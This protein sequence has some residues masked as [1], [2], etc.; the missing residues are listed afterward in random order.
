MKA[1]PLRIQPLREARAWT[2]EE[3]A[4]RVAITPQQVSLYERREQAPGAEILLR[5]A[6]AFGLPAD[7]LLHDRPRW[8]ELYLEKPLLSAYRTTRTLSPPSR[9]LACGWIDVALA[10]PA[11]ALL[12]GSHNVP[13]GPAGDP[14]GSNRPPEGPARDPSR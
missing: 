1:V 13:E 5:L 2:Q 10:G 3:L 12:S 7:A 4:R 14:N 6:A 8:P 11:A 9:E